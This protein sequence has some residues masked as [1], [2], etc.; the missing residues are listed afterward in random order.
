MACSLCT[1]VYFFAIFLNL[2]ILTMPLVL[3]QSLFLFYFLGG[4]KGFCEGLRGVQK[5]GKGIA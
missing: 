3:E 4:I 1:S 2:V 5:A